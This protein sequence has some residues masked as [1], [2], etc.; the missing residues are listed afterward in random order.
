LL[1]MAVAAIA[2]CAAGIPAV[3]LAPDPSEVYRDALYV[4]REALRDEDPVVRSQAIEALGQTEGARAGDDLLRGLSDPS[5]AVR[6]AAAMSLG[7]V[8][9]APALPTLERM[10]R[11]KQAEP[12]RRS[13]CAVLYA[14]YR[15]SG[16]QQARELSSLLFDSQ[17]EVRRCAAMAMGKM[18]EPSAI[19]LLEELDRNE[20]DMSVKLQVAHSLA[21]LD[22]ARS[23]QILEGYARSQFLDDRLVAISAMAEVGSVN[24]VPALRS[25]MGRRLPPRVRV[26]AAGALARLGKVDKSAYRLCCAAAE[27]PRKTMM[28]AM[29]AGGRSRAEI[30]D[31][32]LASLQQIK[33]AYEVLYP[34]LRSSDGSVRVAAAMSLLRLFASYRPVGP[35]PAGARER[36][37]S[38]RPAPATAATKGSA[39]DGARVPKGPGRPVKGTE[40]PDAA[41]RPADPNEEAHP[42]GAGPARRTRRKRAQLYTS[43]AKD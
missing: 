42:A 30:T 29:S 34:L 5:T 33:A 35:P 32:H 39:E 15:I 18:G 24:A 37:V 23:A 2:G 26:A 16:S 38:S 13:Y 17:T 14:L 22:D 11:D 43:G 12:D 8:R 28:K 9:Y 4:L 10:A 7:D 31:V 41:S 36:P 19:V 1:F 40:T 21:L 20:R 25:L 6:F 27:D 3:R